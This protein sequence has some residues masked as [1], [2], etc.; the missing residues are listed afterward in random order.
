[1]KDIIKFDDKGLGKKLGFKKVYYFKELKIENGERK[2]FEDKNVDIITG[3]EKEKRADHM[4]YRSSGLNH[5]LCKLAKENKIK[6]AFS[7]SDV[8]K[9]KGML[10]GQVIGRMMQ[11][12][13][14]CRK[15]RVKMIICS[16]AE[17]KYEMKNVK[18]LIA[19]GRVVGMS[20]GESK[21][22]LE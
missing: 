4:K 6:I 11:N 8:L 21:K 12:V 22:A 5:V 18:D 13:K 15:Y 9:S 14:L 16:F 1:M 7:F 3:L 20:P 17:N 10:R 19:F 2:N